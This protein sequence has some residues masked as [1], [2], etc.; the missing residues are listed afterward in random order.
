[1]SLRETLLA[2]ATFPAPF[3]EQK[4]GTLTLDFV[5][6]ETKSRLSSRKISYHCRVRVD[7]GARTMLFFEILKE[8]G[9][10]IS[11]GDEMGPGFSFK[12]ETYGTAGKERSG[13]LEESSQLIG[14]GYSLSFDY[15]AVRGL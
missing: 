10:G 8:K 12:K 1:M 14:K 11:A 3:T 7:E 6:A 4:D 2:M 15:G 5:A 13:S 9:A